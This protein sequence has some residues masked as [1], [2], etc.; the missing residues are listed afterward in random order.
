MSMFT[1]CTDF[2]AEEEFDETLEQMILSEKNFTSE[3]G[4]LFRRFFLCTSQSRVIWS[5][6]EWESEIHYNNAVQSIMKNRRDN[7]IGYKIF[8][9]EDK[10]FGVGEFSDDLSHIV[11]THGLM[12][13]QAK[14]SFLKD[15]ENRVAKQIEKLSWLRVYHNSYNPDEYIAFLGFVDK[16]I[17]NL[18]H[19][20]GDFQLEEYLL[21]GLRK[22]SGEAFLA[23]YDQ[24]I[25]TPLLL[26]GS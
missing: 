25:C 7:R 1:I 6:T 14:E 13:T 22:P 19:R 5:L 17:L 2:V 20:V 15:Q 21:I 10:K 18:V 23:G 26:T 9:N 11:I 3:I 24:F 8:C 4:V 12:N 16:Y